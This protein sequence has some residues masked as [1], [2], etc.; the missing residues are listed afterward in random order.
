VAELNTKHDAEVT[1][2]ASCGLAATAVEM[3]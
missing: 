2:K 1:L 3:L